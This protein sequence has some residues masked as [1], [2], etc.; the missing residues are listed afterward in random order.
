VIARVLD[1]D[2]I[3]QLSQLIELVIEIDIVLREKVVLA[4]AG[5]VLAEIIDLPART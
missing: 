2:A 3:A 4:R 1:V 5:H